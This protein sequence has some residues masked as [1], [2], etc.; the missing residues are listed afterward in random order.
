MTDFSIK[1]ASQ[2]GLFDIDPALLDAPAP[3]PALAPAHT[4]PP[5]PELVP[6]LVEVPPGVGGG[7]EA[8]AAPA[9][10]APAVLEV[11]AGPVTLVEAAAAAAAA[12][13]TATVDVPNMPEEP[14]PPLRMARQAN[15]SSNSATSSTSRYQVRYVYAYRYAPAVRGGFQ[16]KVM[17][18]PKLK[19]RLPSATPT[20]R[21]SQTTRS[22]RRQP[23][24]VERRLAE[25][26]DIERSSILSAAT[27]R[28]WE[29]LLAVQAGMEFDAAYS[30]AD[31][32][33]DSAADGA[34]GD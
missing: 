33:A 29:R 26:I 32:V 9:F 3:E 13:A 27:A 18:R 19:M 24:P 16:L 20:T 31:G 21:G 14:E 5:K 1:V 11:P 2:A 34:L 15:G 12:T 30:T 6:V 8:F 23:N 22:V 17:L 28:T 25:Q 4:A 10:V 7:G